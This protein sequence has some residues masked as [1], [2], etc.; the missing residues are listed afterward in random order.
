MPVIRPVRACL[1]GVAL[2]SA[3]LLAGGCGEEESP[4]P[5]A[6]AEAESGAPPYAQQ[7]DDARRNYR[8]QEPAQ[9]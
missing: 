4:E 9:D 7:G 1:F 5:A 6:P 8:P 3:L 2:T